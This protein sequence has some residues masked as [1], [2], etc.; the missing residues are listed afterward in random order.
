MEGS[1]RSCNMGMVADKGHPRTSDLGDLKTIR[2]S[3]HTLCMVSSTRKSL[4]HFAHVLL[5]DRR[6]SFLPLSR[7]SQEMD[8]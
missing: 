4:V 3:A 6:F 8:K 2:M 5:M 7:Q 1:C